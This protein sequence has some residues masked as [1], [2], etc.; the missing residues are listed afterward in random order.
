MVS[1]MT[2]DAEDRNEG[3]LKLPLVPNKSSNGCCCCCLLQTTLS[4][5]VTHTSIDFRNKYINSVVI[6]VASGAQILSNNCKHL[7]DCR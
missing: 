3:T 6:V 4:C 5:Q 1:A 2:K 7:Y